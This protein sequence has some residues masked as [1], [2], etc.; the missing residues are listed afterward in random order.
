MKTAAVFSG[1]PL[2]FTKRNA[3]RWFR[4][5]GQWKN[6]EPFENEEKKLKKNKTAVRWAR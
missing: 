4:W 6:S 5:R 3:D 1:Y 2:P